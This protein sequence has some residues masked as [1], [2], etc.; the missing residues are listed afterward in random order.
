MAYTVVLPEP[1]KDTSI[2]TF[3]KDFFWSSQ[4][5]FVKAFMLTQSMPFL[6]AD[7]DGGGHMAEV[8]LQK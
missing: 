6:S 5:N 4:D 1:E 3:L 8:L 2:I 7:D